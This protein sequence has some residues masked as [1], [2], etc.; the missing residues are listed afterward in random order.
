MEALYTPLCN[1]YVKMTK[2]EID[3]DVEEN[4]FSAY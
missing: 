4:Q 2:D 3:K 1:K